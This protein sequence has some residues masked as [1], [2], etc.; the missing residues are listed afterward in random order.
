MRRPLARLAEDIEPVLRTRI[1]A[2]LY[3]SW[4]GTEGFGVH[5]ADHDTVVVQLDRAPGASRSRGPRPLG[6]KPRV[7]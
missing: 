2:D 4:T 7:S 5:W 6:K 1:Q 3:A